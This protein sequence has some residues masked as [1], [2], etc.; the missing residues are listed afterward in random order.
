MCLASSDPSV[1]AEPRPLRCLALSARADR[2]APA[3]R[4][5][6]APPPRPVIHGPDSR[7]PRAEARRRIG[8]LNALFRQEVLGYC[9]P[10]EAVKHT[11][12]H[13]G[14]RPG[15]GA[16]SG[17]SPGPRRYVRGVLASRA[18]GGQGGGS[19]QGGERVL[20]DLIDITGH[21]RRITCALVA[22]RAVLGASHFPDPHRDGWEMISSRGHSC[23]ASPQ[24]WTLPHPEAWR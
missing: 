4:L 22:G 2:S 19:P 17:P 15:M 6:F 8:M 16:F 24:E 18:S 9:W 13:M 11:G 14:P 7:R 5:R 21:P 20:E 10:R 12:P 1:A 3:H 23:S